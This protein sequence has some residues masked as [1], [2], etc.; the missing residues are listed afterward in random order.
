MDFAGGAMVEA[1]AEAGVSVC[2][3]NPGTSEMHLVIALDKAA[4][5]G[6]MR[7]I[8]CLFEGVVT[9]A[10]DGFAR[11][12][13]VPA[14]SLLHL[15]HGLANGLANLHNA[16]WA[17]VP[18]L[19]VVG[20]HASPL[21]RFLA[22][23]AETQS[24]PYLGDIESFASPVS[25]WTR[26]CR[27]AD[28]AVADA[29][30]TVRATAEP[31]GQVATLIVPADV[32]WSQPSSELHQS[33][34][35][36][37]LFPVRLPAANEAAVEQVCRLLLSDGSSCL[38][39]VGG[40]ALLSAGLVAANR[41]AHTS[42][43]GLASNNKVNA[44][45][46]RRGAGTPLITPLPYYYDDIRAAIA[47][48]APQHLI[49][50]GTVV[51]YAAFG[52]PEMSEADYTSLLPEGTT[53]RVLASPAEDPVDALERVAERIGAP[54]ELPPELIAPLAPPLLPSNP[55]KPLSAASIGAA[56]AACLP[57]DAIV[58]DEAITASGGFWA[59]SAGAQAH[60][61]LAVTG[62]SIGVG[63]PLALGAA[64]ACPERRVIALQADGSA[65]YTIQALWT[66][67]REKLPVVVILLANRS[68]SIFST[69]LERL[70]LRCVS[71]V[72]EAR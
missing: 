28:L 13:G 43:A 50:C 10:A 64:V 14:L 56:V 47:Q 23:P 15:G 5:A 55:S 65:M 20:D 41:V 39:L 60:D 44:A 67:A 9:G 27:H 62:G 42:G 59:A 36:A 22:H 37:D 29:W 34:Q 51:P 12:T 40:A 17:R 38:L 30:A 52:Y 61:V 19:N 70:G 18:L 45:R 71:A 66:M 32:A 58:V 2:F 25:G 53:V 1:F 54:E 24:S 69:E 7:S 8:L 6:R 68:Y 72:D 4:E 21:R 33:H 48:L 46:M 31:L 57:H 49:L 26:R 63:L 3:T 11:M 16:K 35:P